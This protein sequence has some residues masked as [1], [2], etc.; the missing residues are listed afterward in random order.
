MIYRKL[1]DQY[2]ELKH[3]E[4]AVATPKTSEYIELIRHLRAIKPGQ[5]GGQTVI[6]GG[7][8]MAGLCSA[9]ELSKLGFDVVLLEAQKTH[10]GGRARTFRLS[11]HVYG[12]FGAMRIP[13]KHELTRFYISEFK[14]ELRKFVQ[15]NPEAI[16]YVRGKRLKVADVEQIKKSFKLSEEEA[17]KSTLDYWLEI[18][19]ALIASLNELQ[20]DELFNSEIT[21]AT[22]KELDNKSL[23][24]VLLQGGFSKEAIEMLVSTWGFET[25]LQFSLLEFL[26]EEIEGIWSGE[27]D[28]IVGGTDLLAKAF[29]EE[30]KICTFQ[31]AIITNVEQSSNSVTVNYKNSDGEKDSVTGN[32]FICTLPLGVLDKVSFE[33]ALSFAKSEAIR[34]VNYDSSTKILAHTTKRFWELDDQIYGGGSSSDSLIGSTWYPSDNPDKDV[35]VSNS[36]SMFLSSYTWGQSARRM[37]QIPEADLKEYMTNELGNLH[38]SLLKD[39]SAIKMFYRW[40]WTNCQWSNGAYSF[41]MPNEHSEFYKDLIEP[42]GKILL[43]GE[44][45]SLTH[46]WM[47]G[48]FESALRVV[49]HIV[50]TFKAP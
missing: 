8:G 23:Y 30:L 37:D 34:R 38:P 10:I 44:H 22:I 17:G 41:F 6:I 35:K 46:S 11:E 36:E 45:A 13:E 33:P 39:P 14:L 43:A 28:E 42:E 48:A 1:L 5:F 20:K 12:E 49:S 26:R 9:Y 27:F 16:S 21:D 47:Q 24:E 31:N 50:D 2:A 29:H 3:L 32:W 19:V 7:A 25:S 4:K 40:S 15:A 18:I